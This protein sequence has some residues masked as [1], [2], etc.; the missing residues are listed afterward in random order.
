MHTNAP[1]MRSHHVF[2]PRHGPLR[3][4]DVWVL[5]Q[6]VRAFWGR[7][8]QSI[9][10]ETY[11]YIYCIYIY[12]YNSNDMIEILYTSILYYTH[13]S[14]FLLHNVSMFP[15]NRLYDYTRFIVPIAHLPKTHEQSGK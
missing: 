12:T 1:G 2:G 3:R 5:Q 13:A 4:L 14:G 7:N 9:N 11:I 8:D 15:A 10:R 6:K